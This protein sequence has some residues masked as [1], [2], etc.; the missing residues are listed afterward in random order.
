MN[1]SPNDYHIS[2]FKPTTPQAKANRNMAVWLALIWAVSIF[3]FQFLLRILE[4][5]TPEPAYSTFEQV[6]PEILKGEATQANLQELSKVSLSV[7][8]KIAIAP[9][10]KPVLDNAFNWSVFQLITDS[11]QEAYLTKIA[12][13]EKYKEEIENINDKKYIDMKNT[14]SEALSKVIG[15]DRN[16]V[17]TTILPLELNSVQCKELSAETYSNLPKV[18]EKYLVHNQS[19]LTDT[20]ILGFPFHYFYTAVFLLILFVGLCWIYCVRTDNLNA[21]FN[22][23]D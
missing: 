14:L 11:V 16:D 19:V 22:I 18:M 4:K 15:L 13:F 17:R 8:G 21:K 20:V 5:P 7:L 23:A 6:W 2:F 9:E 1:D 3:G 10:D 12:G